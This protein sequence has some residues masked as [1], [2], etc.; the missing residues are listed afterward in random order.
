VEFIDTYHLWVYGRLKGQ[1]EGE[2]REWLRR[3]TDALQG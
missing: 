3:A 1:L 2:Q